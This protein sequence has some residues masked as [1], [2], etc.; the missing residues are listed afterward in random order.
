MRSR[1]KSDESVPA[2]MRASLSRV[3]CFSSSFSD[4]DRKLGRFCLSVDP[5]PEKWDCAARTL[6]LVLP[7]AVPFAWPF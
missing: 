3:E 2:R 7:L 6:L 4:A 1:P 5:T